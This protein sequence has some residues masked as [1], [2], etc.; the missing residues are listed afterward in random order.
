MATLLWLGNIS[1]EFS[2]DNMKE[3]R[4]YG[5]AYDFNI[6]YDV[7]EVIN[8]PDIQKYLMKKNVII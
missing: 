8:L 6:Y 4:L 2:V 5:Y 1:K 3:T 7:T